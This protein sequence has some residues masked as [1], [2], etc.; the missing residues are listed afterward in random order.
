MTEGQYILLLLVSLAVTF[1]AQMLV[2]SRYNK[3]SKVSN[4]AG[5]NGENIARRMLEADGMLDVKVVPIKGTLTD[6]YNPTT[7]TVSLSEDIFY[8][9]TI[10]GVAVAAHECGHAIQHHTGYSFIKVRSALIPVLNFTSRFSYIMIAAGA[11]LGAMKL[12]E[13]GIILEAVA[14][15]FQ[16][17][18][19]PVE[20]NAS[21][22]G[23]EHLKS[24]NVFNSQE[25][26]GCKS[27]LT[28]A[29][30]TYVGAALSAIVSLLRLVLIMNNSR[31]RD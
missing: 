18:T 22:R 15:L 11:I 29:A 26:S 19:L 25:L 28:A 30:L 13:I 7:K 5:L 16:L 12:F 9:T 10:A 1:I 24:F 20:F 27:M 8:G 31:R 23:M 14:V 17:V 6:N 2:K 21:R 3:Y 4:S